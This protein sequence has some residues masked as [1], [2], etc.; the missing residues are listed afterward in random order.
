MT[1][2]LVDISATNSLQHF[3]TSQ[4]SEHRELNMLTEVYIVVD[5][6]SY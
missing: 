3:L 4:P 5:K 6:C 1:P 2:V